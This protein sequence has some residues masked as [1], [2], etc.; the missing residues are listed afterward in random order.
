MAVILYLLLSFGCRR[1]VMSEELTQLIR[2]LVV[3]L[4]YFHDVSHNLKALTGK[5]GITVIFKPDLRLNRLTPFLAEK[6]SGCSNNHKESSG[7]CDL[8]V[9][10]KI[11]V[12]RGPC[13]GQTARSINDRLC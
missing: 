13:F 8:N 11:P 9:V 2:E 7:S 4:P 10:Y 12:K 3:S 6:E 5:F 1:A